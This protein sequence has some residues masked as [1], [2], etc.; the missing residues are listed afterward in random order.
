VTG[1]VAIVHVLVPEGIDDPRRPSGGNAY[2]RRLIEELP[3]WGWEV[4]EHPVP[5]DWPTPAQADI[6]RFDEHLADLPDHSVVLV[7]GLIASGAAGLV[8][9]ANRLRIAVLVHMP[10]ATERV[11]SD[12]LNAA[13]AVVTTSQWSRDRVV[14]QH[15]LDPNRVTVALPGV[16]PGP[17]SPGTSVG[18][19]LLV[20]GPL[21]P[22]KGHDLLVT[23]LAGLTDLTWHCTFVGSLDLD[24][25][26]V[27]T[28]TSAVA[29]AGIADRFLFSGPLSRAAL[30]DLRTRTDLVVSASRREA[31][32]MAVAEGLARGI[33]AVATDVG[34]HA[35]A[36]GV[37]GDGSRPG[38]LIRAND[39]E[40]LRSALRQW[41]TEPAVRHRWRQSAALRRRELPAWAQTA[42]TV[43]GVLAEVA[44]EPGTASTAF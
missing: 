9:A 18:R 34:G 41:M 13:A 40:E 16:D 23:A 20:V 4:H 42:Q 39:I 32:G 33:P 21:V 7:D 38:A 24:H 35:E 43:A 5:G 44:R 37:T 8:Q 12:V 25:E 27:R 30:D 29:Q 28:L 11:E 36:V 17:Q 15:H 2:D 26:F 6:S 1:K 31:Y 22:A 19:N 10:D 14:A 3:A